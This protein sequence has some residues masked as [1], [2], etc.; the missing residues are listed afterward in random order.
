MEVENNEGT[1]V[2]APETATAEAEGSSAPTEPAKSQREIELEQEVEKWQKEAKAHQKT[3]SK[4]AQEAQ[5]ITEIRE[6]IKMLRAQ[7]EALVEYLSSQ[8]TSDDDFTEPKQRKPN[9]SEIVQAKTSKIP[10]AA[11]LA[12]QRN[13][14]IAKEINTLAASK[15]LKMGESDELVPA[16]K[17]WAQGKTEEALEKVQEIVG[18]MTEAKKEE[19]KVDIEKQIQEGVQKALKSEL[20]KRGLLDTETGQSK[21]GTLSDADFEKQMA[22]GSLPITKDNIA[23]LTRIHGG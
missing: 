2:V 11:Q 9:L 16:L 22:D 19:P 23:R 7:N 4:K 17:L 13:L 1:G 8:G 15:G 12:E 20:E 14:E 21:G 3:A 5:G 18:K 10:T 6:E